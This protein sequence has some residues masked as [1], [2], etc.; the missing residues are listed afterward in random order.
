[1]RAEKPP[2]KTKTKCAGIGDAKVYPFPQ[3]RRLFYVGPIR[4]VDWRKLDGSLAP[5]EAESPTLPPGRVDL[6]GLRPAPL[7]T[8][9]GLPS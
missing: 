7:S 6:P 5:L 2:A 1:M 3:L 4:D 8:P 9:P